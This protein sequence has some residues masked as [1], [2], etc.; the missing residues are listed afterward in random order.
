MP[1]S[2][3]PYLPPDRLQTL[4]AGVNLPLAADGSVL[5]ADISGFTPVTE[6]LR[7]TLGRRRGAEELTSHLNRV[8][9]ALIAA[10]ELY[11]GSII[12]FAGDAITCW[13]GGEST[14]LRAVACGFALLDAMSPVAQIALPDGG[15][16]E[17]GLKVVISSGETKRF[18]VGE[19]DIQ[20][21]DA[22]AGM[23]VTRLAIG[24]A[25]VKRGEVL[26]DEI[27]IQRLGVSVPV[28]EWRASE[29]ER[30]AVLE[31]FEPAPNL[32]SPFQVTVLSAEQLR[33]WLLPVLARHMDAGLGEFQIELRP[34]TTLFLR[35]SGI[36]YDADNDAEARLN[37]LVRLVQ[38]IVQRYEGNVLQLTIGDKGSYLY[39]VFGAPVAHEDDTVRTLNA[40]L[41]IRVAV[42]ELD[43]IDPVQIGISRGIMRTGAYGSASRRTYGV[44]GDET[45]LAARLMTQA[46][47][48]TILLSESLLRANLDDFTLESLPP[49]QVKGK[50]NP[51]QVFRLTGRRE[52][53]FEARFY[54]TPLVGREDE[55]TQVRE[56]LQPIFDGRH[57][58][59]I[60]V[61][62][63]PGMG[64]SR[65][66]FEAQ[67]RLQAEASVTW[68][69]GQA[70]QLN[71]APL[72]VFAYFLRPHFG[73]RRDAER[74]VNL[75][76]FDA[77]FESLLTLSDEANRADLLLYQSY[78]AGLVGLV[79]SGSPYE[80]A[81]E[82]LRIDNGI[83]ALKAWARAESVRQ[84]LVIHLEDAKWLDAISLRAVQ[85]LTYNM[86]DVPLALLLTSRYNDDGTPFAIPNIYSVPVYALDLNR[87]ND[88]GVRSV[89]QAVTGGGLSDQL[90]QF[91]RERA[92]GNPF[93]T[94][95][96]V[97]DLEERGVL[98]ESESGWDIDPDAAAEVPSGVNA[99]L[100]ARLDRLAGQVKL[101]VQTGA[102]L[103]REFDV[104][105][106]SRMLRAEDSPAI[107]EAERE[108]IWSALDELRYL[109]RHALLRD[110]AYHMQAQQR[111][112]ELHRLAAETIEILYPEDET[113]Y[114][115]LL[116]HWD[117]A[118]IAD[119]FLY[120]TMPVC[121]RLVGITADY[122]RAE[123]LLTKALALGETPFRATLLRL[124]GDSLQL[125]GEYSTAAAQY[126]ACLS[127]SGVEVAPRIQALNGLSKIRMKQG[128]NAEAVALVEQGLA[129]ADAHHQSVETARLLVTLGTLASRQGENDIARS[130]YSEGLRIAREL[131]QRAEM[132]NV[133]KSLAMVE[134]I[135]SNHTA[136]REYLAESLALAQ[137]IGDR[138]QT[139]GA[140]QNIGTTALQ[141]GDHKAARTYYEASLNIWREIGSRSGIADVWSNLAILAL[142]QG[143]LAAAQLYGDN[144]LRE[145]RAIGDQRGIAN[146][147]SIVAVVAYEQ[148][149]YVAAE[150]YFEEILEMQRAINDRWGMATTFGNLGEI[151][152]FRGDFTK[153]EDYN[154]EALALFRQLDQP[155][156]IA[157]T[158][159]SQA[160]IAQ[161]KGEIE[162]S[163]EL[164]EEALRIRREIND[165]LGI[166][167][168]VTALAD[169]DV[170]TDA[171]PEA[172][173]QLEEVL[174][175]LRELDHSVLPTTLAQLAVV[176]RRLGESGT[177]VY[178]LIREALTLAQKRKSH[179]KTLH[180]LI[181]VAQ[182][183]LLDEKYIML[184]ELNGLLLSND[185]PP[186]SMRIVEGLLEQLRSRLE[187]T[188]LVAA[189]ERGKALDLD[190]TINRLLVELG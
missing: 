181:Q 65:L 10:V 95:Q 133:L 138:Q 44:H 154:A 96:L 55:L 174:I 173:Q 77:G 9:D 127:V 89:A 108:S 170:Q 189:L 144:S 140:Y 63:E 72:N 3:A 7:V 169:L 190:E 120:Y 134:S 47:P 34:V 121:E 39:V 177:S 73:Q 83:A 98:V 33:A 178:S 85:Q 143:N 112:K 64:K 128:E 111:L 17:L 14:A 175:L 152:G 101:V 176:K 106:L 99:V 185:L 171:L 31:P 87:L 130:H 74:E 131:R 122:V 82:K 90:V 59:L 91:V 125:R 19:P 66:A 24:E 141:Q 157:N 2:V 12:G 58:G 26:A 179:R 124:L 56:A 148:Q 145:R 62:G 116:E 113:Q 51:I 18:V 107:R 146:S 156:G 15:T 71:R 92:E 182:I 150:R 28:R 114:D 11:N 139:A 38:G 69:T 165:Q 160:D 110:A 67:Q 183:L 49:I 126:E 94:E 135:K 93:F 37:R 52:R 149:D 162:T 137:E 16:L 6:S 29:T 159:T 103:G 129:L 132:I 13:F 25:L 32:A 53:S 35:F 48:G 80:V 68:L 180:A 119:K 79:I 21:I 40:A 76:A 161:E 43:G 102:V 187:P 86:D 136:A 147:L 166:A 42:A 188:M 8:Y 167:F 151:A 100:I 61:Y 142:R 45:N 84:P 158:L 30:F 4:A 163:R 54:T 109:F 41:D 155:L 46:E 27:T 36:D 78:L 70:D 153:A 172:E 164:H 105:V 23:T 104:M 75:S 88:E 1:P 123:H 186:S 117:E 168:S 57:A 118:G 184:G 115:T 60:Y 20:L 5:F 50:A 22:I 97:L 81:D